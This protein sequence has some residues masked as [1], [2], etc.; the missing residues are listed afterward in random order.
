M[1]ENPLLGR[2]FKKVFPPWRE[3]S[4]GGGV[5]QRKEGPRVESATK[6]ILGEGG[7]EH[8]PGGVA[9]TYMQGEIMWEETPHM[10]GPHTHI[11]GSLNRGG[12]R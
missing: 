5:S 2:S 3:Y 8:P 4:Q 7:K 10:R 1:K 11:T 9:T 12:E 6:I